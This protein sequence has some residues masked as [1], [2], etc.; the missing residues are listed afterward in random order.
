MAR[1]LGPAFYC[2]LCERPEKD[3][4]RGCPQ[5]QLTEV[6]NILY[7][8]TVEEVLRRNRFQE[9]FQRWGSVSLQQIE[10]LHSLV[11]KLMT[12][13]VVWRGSSLLLAK[14]ADIVQGERT[15]AE[16]VKIFNA[17]AELRARNK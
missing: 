17:E 14:L 12:N 15:Q 11:S 8:V 13:D 10:R 9:R 16:R 7:A 5:C 4:P 6:Q 1:E 3:L 2:P